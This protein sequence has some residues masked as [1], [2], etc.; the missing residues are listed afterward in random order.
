MKRLFC[1]DEGAAIKQLPFRRF[2]FLPGLLAACLILSCPVPAGAVSFHEME[3]TGQMDLSFAEQYSVDY[4][5]EGYSL[6]TIAGSEEYLLVP[7]NLPVPEDLPDDVTVL[8][9]PLESIYLGSS[10]AMDLFLHAG[11][12]AD[13]SMTST[14]EQNWTIPEIKEALENGEI[15][16]VGKYSAPDYEAIM[17]NGCSLAV[18]NTMIFHSPEIK[19]QLEKLGI[20]VLVERS[21]Y[22]THPL[23]RVEWIRLYGLLTG[24]QEEADAFFRAG[25]DQVK[26]L[27]DQEE[28]G[29]TVAFFYITSSGE[30]NVRKPGDYISKMIEMAGGKYLLSDME[31]ETENALSTMNMQFESFY[32][33]AK[34]AD[35]LI[36][37]STVETELKSVDELIAKNPLFSEFK[38]VREGSVYCTK[39]NMFQQVSGT[40]E[41]ITDL[42][43][44]ICGEDGELTYLTKLE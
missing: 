11:A 35:I 38:A 30:V 5:K 36:Y 44:V 21:S 3:I 34:E 25:A 40:A 8:R 24:K 27:A 4:Y 41:M 6:I 12:L 32:A 7:E 20:P 9:Q 10:S 1:F 13:V 18:E 37:N 42:H 2:V 33:S 43:T 39:Q 14:S 19:E 15:L 16:Y 28:A 31:D 22:E 26:S 23:G 29:R 17:A